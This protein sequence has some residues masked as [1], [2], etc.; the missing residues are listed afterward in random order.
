VSRP[1]I[2]RAPSFLPSCPLAILPYHL[3]PALSFE[4]QNTHIQPFSLSRTPSCYCLCWSFSSSSTAAR[5]GK[6]EPPRLSRQ[7]KLTAFSIFSLQ[8]ASTAQSIGPFGSLSP[9]ILSVSR[10]SFGSLST[11]PA[12]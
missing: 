8:D 5:S 4:S 1:R 11:I 3:S 12:C 6:N 2:G 9:N 7:R 10:V